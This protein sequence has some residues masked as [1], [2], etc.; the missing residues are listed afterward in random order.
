MPPS[1]R[2]E[3]LGHET[4]AARVLEVEPGVY[5]VLRRCSLSECG[6]WFQPG[7]GKARYCCATHRM[8]AW[9]HEHRGV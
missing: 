7:T 6:A 3:G 2:E 9:R 1:A 4:D 5:V 8:K